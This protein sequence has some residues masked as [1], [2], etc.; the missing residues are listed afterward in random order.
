MER[1]F[2]EA[3]KLNMLNELRVE[4]GET[5]KFILVQVHHEELVSGS[6]LSPLACKL[7]IKIGHILPMPLHLAQTTTALKHRILGWQS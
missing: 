6:Q 7:A 1:T 3:I 2:K 5:G 4:E